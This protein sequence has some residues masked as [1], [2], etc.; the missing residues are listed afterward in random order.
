MGK[1]GPKSQ[2]AQLIFIEEDGLWLSV[3]AGH[4]ALRQRDGTYT[5]LP[6]T[7]RSIVAAGH[8]F[9]VTDAAI[10]HCVNNHVEL[11]ISGTAPAF[12]SL[13]SAQPLCD[14]SRAALNLRKRQFE[15]LHDREKTVQIAAKIVAKKVRRERHVK[16]DEREFLKQ[17]GTASSTSEVRH[18]EAQSAGLWWRQWQGFELS[19]DG[20]RVPAAWRKF[21]TRYIGRRQGRLGELPMQYTTRGAIH[22]MQALLNFATS[23]IAARLTR[24]V[25]AYGLDPAFGFLHDGRKPGR[26]SLVWDCIE[27]LRP[28]LVTAV[29]EYARTRVFDPRA[30]F[31]VFVHK[32]TGERT[33]RLA[34]P[35]IKDVTGVALRAAPLTACVKAVKEA[36][37]L[38]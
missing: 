3:R 12:V 25:I 35:A 27:P 7:V 28:A 26:L 22:P 15:A 38:F 18:I 13:F 9:A 33:V 34:A 29:F 23:I 19:F 5:W 4:L 11:L 6:D 37:A 31:C 32:I 24:C 30:D 20:S 2:S 36:A 17:L 8:G 10:R 16:A 21:E 14:A 1:R